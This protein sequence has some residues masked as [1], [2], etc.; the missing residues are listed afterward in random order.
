MLQFAEDLTTNISKTA[1]RL[2]T[3]VQ[4]ARTTHTTKKEMAA[5][6]SQQPMIEKG[7]LFHIAE[8]FETE[9]TVTVGHVTPL[10]VSNLLSHVGTTKGLLKVSP[11]VNNISFAEYTKGKVFDIP[12]NDDDG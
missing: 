12:Q 3:T 6:V 7:L 4:T 10:L 1:R 11:L 9:A 5:F 8:L 2:L